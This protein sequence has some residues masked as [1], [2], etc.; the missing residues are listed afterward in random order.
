[1]DYSDVIRDS[2]VCFECIGE[3]RVGM[4]AWEM[5]M[6][7]PECPDGRRLVVIANDTTYQIGSFGPEE[8][9]VFQ[10]ASERARELGV[11]RVFLACNAGAR[12]G[13]ADECR[14][15]FHVAWRDPA[16]P[17]KAQS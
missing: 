8:D 10:A 3:N 2:C 15:C 6:R 11:P 14:D 1:M 4:V 5:V 17:D 12:I 13:L 16:N 9:R 7:T